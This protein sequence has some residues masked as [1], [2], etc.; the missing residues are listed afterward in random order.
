MHKL[1]SREEISSWE[2]LAEKY[3]P[4]LLLTENQLSISKKTVEKR[5]GEYFPEIYLKGSLSGISAPFLFYP[6][7]SFDDQTL[8][9]GLTV[10][11]SWNLFDGLGRERRIKAAKYERNAFRFE[12]ENALLQAYADV[13]RQIFSIEEAIASYLSSKGNIDLAKETVELAK[14][15]LEVG[16]VTIYDYQISVDGLIQ[17]RFNFDQSEFDILVAYYGLRHASGIDA[18]SYL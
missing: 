3:R 16:Y 14:E 6:K 8:T 17:A 5:A 2:S 7:P 9:Y 4:S 11:L 13:R 1:Y 18:D 10:S 15:R 12:Y